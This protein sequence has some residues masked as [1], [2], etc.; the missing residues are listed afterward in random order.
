MVMFCPRW[1]NERGDFLRKSTTRSFT[2]MVNKDK[3][4]T[5][6]VQWIQKEGWLEQLRMIGEIEALI[7]RRDEMETQDKDGTHTGN[8]SVIALPRGKTVMAQNPIRQLS[9]FFYRE[10][11]S[12]IAS[13]IRNVEL[14]TGLFKGLA[15]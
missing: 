11:S 9:G 1:S 3:D 10:V 13:R 6:I 15:L 12:Y 2:A 14:Q 8:N 5:R 7:R 4:V